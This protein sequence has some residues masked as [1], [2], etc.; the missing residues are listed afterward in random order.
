MALEKISEAGKGVLLYIEQEGRG[1]GLVNKIRA[2]N[3]QD[4]GD[5]TVDAN[6]KLGM[7]ADLRDYGIGAQILVD[8][9]LQKIRYMT[10]NP[11]KLAGVEGFGLEITEVVPIRTHPNP[12]NERYLATKRERMG[13]LLPHEEQ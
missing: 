3:L 10:N 11:A 4:K 12:Y 13:H 8:L 5:D 9:G 1:I 6:L 2:Y 7:K